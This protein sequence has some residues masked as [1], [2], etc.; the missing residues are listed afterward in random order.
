MI[1]NR[2]QN[3]EEENKHNKNEHKPITLIK[4]WK[5]NEKHQNE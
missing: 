1:H 2:K 3:N 5:Q 4:K